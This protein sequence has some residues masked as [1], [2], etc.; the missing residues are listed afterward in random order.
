[1]QGIKN[2]IALAKRQQIV[3]GSM[4]TSR[5]PFGYRRI[6]RDRIAS[7]EVH[8]EEAEIVREI[9]QLAGQ[10]VSLRRIGTHLRALYPTRVT[11]SGKVKQCTWRPCAVVYLLKNTAY[12]GRAI[13]GRFQLC[14]PD[15]KARRKSL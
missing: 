6:V 12:T 15:P 3:S 7:L 4:T 9:F 14:E 8:P 2:R 11:R 13:Q 5:V 1:K 10:G